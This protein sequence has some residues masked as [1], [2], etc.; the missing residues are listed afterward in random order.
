ME[1][2]FNLFMLSFGKEGKIGIGDGVAVWVCLEGG[3]YGEGLSLLFEGL[4]WLFMRIFVE[5]GGIGDGDV[6]F[7][8]FLV[9]SGWG[10]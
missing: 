7:V 2:C 4:V 3:S 8:C 6:D 10:L 9:G 1:Q 5:E